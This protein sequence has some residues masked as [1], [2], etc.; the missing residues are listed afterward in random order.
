MD[1]LVIFLALYILFVFIALFSHVFTSRALKNFDL[2]V[3]H[4]LD[5]WNYYWSKCKQSNKGV[6][7]YR[8]FRKFK[9]PYMI[10]AFSK[11]LENISEE[12]RALLLNANSN[13]IFK[14]VKNSRIDI[15]GY[16]AYMLSDIAW[17]KFDGIRAYEDFLLDFA[18]SDSVFLRENALKALYN[19]GNEK[20]IS[21]AYVKLSENHITHSEKLLADGLLEYKGD[22]KLLIN[23]LIRYYEKYDECYKVALITF[24]NYEDCHKYDDMFK[25]IV[26]ANEPSNIQCAILRLV[27]KDKSPA[28]GEF[29]ARYIDTHVDI[30]RWESTTVAAGILGSFE[31]SD[32]IISTLKRAITSKVWSIRMNSAKSL[33]ALGINEDETDEITK[34]K[35][36]FA[37]EALVYA[38]NI[39]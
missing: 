8:Y 16:F 19:A 20:K 22:K 24:L 3:E 2:N 4:G 13:K 14:I 33:C 34:G 31:K 23:E 5:K 11:L 26:E 7:Y 21:K 35:D 29:I 1:Y 28:N 17:P 15:K 32:Y 10:I 25:K 37:K 39:I 38:L 6:L 18:I 30:D 9:K 27:G 12:D 36:L